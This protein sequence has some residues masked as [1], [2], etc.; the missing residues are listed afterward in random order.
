MVPSIGSER[1]RGPIGHR[2]VLLALIIA[3]LA[4]LAMGEANSAAANDLY[5]WGYE[6]YDFPPL[7]TSPD[8][9]RR[10]CLAAP[11]P[12][13]ATPSSMRASLDAACNQL[14]V[15]LR[16]A[17]INA[18]PSA[19]CNIDTPEGGS[20]MCVQPWACGNSLEAQST[21]SPSRMHIRNA[22]GPSYLPFLLLLL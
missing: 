8:V 14:I 5:N 9:T 11:V 19:T 6:Y 22:I 3:T 13:G 18:F 4:Q 7:C 15:A 1:W 12:L 17:G 16:L 20:V 10:L 2:G 21:T